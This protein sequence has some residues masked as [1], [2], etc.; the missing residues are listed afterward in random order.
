MYSYS[1]GKVYGS[2]VLPTTY[3]ADDCG[4]KI[5]LAPLSFLILRNLII[6]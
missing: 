6:N 2:I 1:I 3:Q 4:F 5:G